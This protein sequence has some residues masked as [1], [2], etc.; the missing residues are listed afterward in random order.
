MSD[1]IG[2]KDG[3]VDGRLHLPEYRI[4]ADGVLRQADLLGIGAQQAEKAAIEGAG[5]DWELPGAQAAAQR[6]QAAAAEAKRQPRLLGWNHDASLP[7]KVRKLAAKADVVFHKIAKAKNDGDDA[8]LTDAGMRKAC[9]RYAMAEQL[10]A[11]WHLAYL[12]A[13]EARDRH[14]EA[15]EKTGNW[16]G[17]GM[18]PIASEEDLA[19]QVEL[20]LRR[21]DTGE[22]DSRGLPQFRH[23]HSR[24]SWYEWQGNGWRRDV[25][26]R[27]RNAVRE[28][29]VCLD[30]EPRWLNQKTFGAIGA[31]LRATPGFATDGTDWDADPWLLG[32]PEGVVDL[33]T[34]VMREAR[35]ED[36]ITNCC[37]VSPEPGEPVLWLKFLHEATGGDKAFVDWLQKLCGYQLTGITTEQILVFLHGPGGNG[38]G[39]FLH[40]VANVVGDYAVAAAETVIE[41]REQS[42]HPTDLA[43]LRHARLVYIPETKQNGR[44]ND[45]RVQQLTG[46]D[47]VTCRFM[48]QD[49]FTYVPKFKLMISG[50]YAPKLSSVG[51][52]M[53]RRLRV[54]PFIKKPESP[55]LTLEEKLKAEWP[56]ILNWMIE[57]AVK[58]KREGL[59]TFAA[60]EDATT[61]Y[62]GEQDIL[63][64]FIKE[65]CEQEAG[66]FAYHKTLVPEYNLYRAR[67]GLRPVDQNDM[68]AQLAAKGLK[69]H[70]RN[71]GRGFKGIR[72]VKTVNDLPVPAK[73]PEDAQQ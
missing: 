2:I 33:R 29:V 64:D 6:Q 55:D 34:G 23:D 1:E 67:A 62:F 38:K 50:N 27:F 20:L 63:E 56:Q 19:G 4:G 43:A 36:L 9:E 32:T 53:K 70:A 44:W 8:S 48:Q 52:S 3:G 28:A 45:E 16:K 26:E 7:V 21:Q 46:G 11:E 66:S 30:P 68:A 14:L 40:T 51:D 69:R 12:D 25:V 35:R 37:A 58:W 54:V 60:Q 22:S 24:G 5:D 17:S 42:A 41:A 73:T 49:L 72:L 15:A 10:E 31:R 47:P 65:H 18:P 13:Q 61:D 71:D 59:G 57:G 39:V